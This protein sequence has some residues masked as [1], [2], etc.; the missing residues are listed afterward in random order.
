LYS[1]GKAHI[2]TLRFPGFDKFI[3]IKNTSKTAFYSNPPACCG[4]LFVLCVS[5]VL[6]SNTECLTQLVCAQ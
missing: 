6:R 2:A 5:V 1:R 3:F 4:H